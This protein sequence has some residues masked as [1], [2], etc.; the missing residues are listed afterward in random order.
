MKIV[1]IQRLVP[2]YREVVFDRMRAQCEAAGDT[3][4]L[5]TSD[6]PEG[7]TRRGTHGAAAWATRF[8]VWTLLGGIEWQR[9]AW[10]DVL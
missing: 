5:W 6:P 1:L 2:T 4:E 9:L 3:F 8:P 7:F 10:R